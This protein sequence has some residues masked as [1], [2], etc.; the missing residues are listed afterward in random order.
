MTHSQKGGALLARQLKGD[1]WH[2]AWGANVLHAR[3]NSLGQLLVFFSVYV[4]ATPKNPAFCYELPVLFQQGLHHVAYQPGT[5]LRLDSM[6]CFGQ[7]VAK[8]RP[9]ANSLRGVA[10]IL[11]CYVEVLAAGSG[12]PELLPENWRVV[13]ARV[14]PIP[15]LVDLCVIAGGANREDKAALE[16]KF[17][18][19]GAFCSRLRAASHCYSA[20]PCHPATDAAYVD[21][22]NVADQTISTMGSSE[23]LCLFPSVRPWKT[24]NSRNPKFCILVTNGHDGT[25]TPPDA[26]SS[27]S[28]VTSP[29]S[30]PWKSKIR[31][32]TCNSRLC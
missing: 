6:L 2:L 17:V 5:C 13:K 32:P 24:Q 1:M 30:S 8:A 7:H 10:G 26:K 31:L 3:L 12:I 22:R 29:L 16:A 20:L 27:T 14:G 4:F 21:K 11:V 25:L 28:T 9:P 23:S 19:G 18:D 15:P